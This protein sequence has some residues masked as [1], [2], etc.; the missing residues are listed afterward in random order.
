MGRRRG[1][2]ADGD[3][4]NGADGD[5]GNEAGERDGRQRGGT[6]RVVNFKCSEF[7]LMSY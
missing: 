3:A 4:G 6:R 1:N 2:G 7:L 5:A